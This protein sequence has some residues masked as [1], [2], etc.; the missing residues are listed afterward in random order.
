MEKT[1]DPSE[2]CVSAVR[3]EQDLLM[4]NR[5]LGGILNFLFGEAPEYESAGATPPLQTGVK[6][7][8]PLFVALTTQ[9]RTNE[10]RLGDVNYSVGRL[11]ALLGI[12]QTATGS[13]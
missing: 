12:S 11:E 1:Y 10:S 3:M 7:T 13:R 4:L 5:R 2:L 9:M 6:E 8:L